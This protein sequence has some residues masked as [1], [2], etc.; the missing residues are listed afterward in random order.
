MHPK[1]YRCSQNSP[2]LSSPYPP[3]YTE[4]SGP[5]LGRN[6]WYLKGVPY[7]GY[8][9]EQISQ[10]STWED[11]ERITFA[12]LPSGSSNDLARGLGGRRAVRTYGYRLCGSQ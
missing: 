5:P 3:R 8:W 9:K 12:Y 7:A 11:L 2:G 4:E 1:S 6:T 10:T